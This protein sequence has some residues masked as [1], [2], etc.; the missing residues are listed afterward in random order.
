M[1]NVPTQLAIVLSFLAA[2]LTSAAERPDVAAQVRP[3]D[4]PA[5]LAAVR[6]VTKRPV[7][8][9]SAVVSRKWPYRYDPDHVVVSTGPYAV[10]VGDAFELQKANGVW[11]ISG[12]TR[13][14]R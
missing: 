12:K 10:G 5:I 4:V 6:G 13:W 14:I 3:T 2:V 8:R 7:F 11:R 1:L 9:I